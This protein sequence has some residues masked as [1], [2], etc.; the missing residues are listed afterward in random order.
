MCQLRF[1]ATPHTRSRKGNNTIWTGLA[2][3]VSGTGSSGDEWLGS[4]RALFR[5]GVCGWVRAAALSPQQAGSEQVRERAGGLRACGACVAVLLLL[6]LDCCCE[7][8]PSSALML[9]VAA[10]CD[11]SLSVGWFV[12]C[13]N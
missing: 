6:L 13:V 4:S 5:I 8:Y 7:V 3:A 9:S 11:A 2:S 1:E 12:G 10:P